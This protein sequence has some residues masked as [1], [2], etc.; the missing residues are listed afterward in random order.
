MDATKNINTPNQRVIEIPTHKMPRATKKEG[1]KPPFGYF[2][3]KQRISKKIIDMLPPHNAWVE[4]FCGSAAIT[5]AKPPA[6][7][8]IINDLD[9][10]IVNFFQQLRDNQEALIRAIELTPYSNE[11]F[12]N[13]RSEVRNETGGL[14]K[15]RHFLVHAMMT[16]NGTV[17]TTGGGFS[18]TNSYTRNNR[19]ARVNRWYNLPQRL[20]EVVERLRRIRIENRDAA[21]LV[22]MYSNRPAT[23]IYLDPPYFTDRQHGYT[24]DA[25]DEEFHINLLKVC[26]KSK[27]MIILS[28]YDNPLYNEFLTARSGWNK[29]F[30][31]TTTRNTTGTDYVREETLWLNKTLQKAKKQNKLPI[32]LTK[33]ELKNGKLNPLRK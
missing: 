26:I 8:E 27:S 32:R 33:S 3:A 11:E 12:R 25:R 30:I 4:G 2:G 22:S 19:E 17:D 14:E 20:E 15:A 18:Y 31:R 7:I 10:V 6:P 24:I 1:C 23:L 28:G 13:A 16:I 21:E 5:F 9:S 29:H